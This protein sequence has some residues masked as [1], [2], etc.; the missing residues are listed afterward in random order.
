MFVFTLGSNFEHIMTKRLRERQKLTRRLI[1]WPLKIPTVKNM[2][3]LPKNRQFLTAII[4][5][6]KVAK[7]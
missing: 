1:V 3:G 4:L 6:S 7:T 5:T 2:A